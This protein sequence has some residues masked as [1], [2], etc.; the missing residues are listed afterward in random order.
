MT[1]ISHALDTVSTDVD[2][3]LVP[4]IMLFLLLL[5]LGTPRMILATGFRIGVA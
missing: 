2:A 3:I 5:H 4:P 1:T